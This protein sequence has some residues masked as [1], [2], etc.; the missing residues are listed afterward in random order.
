MKSISIIKSFFWSILL[1]PM[2][3]LGQT[4]TTQQPAAPAEE[5]PELISPSMEFTGVQ[6]GDNSI[7]L[8][9]ALKAKVNGQLI[10]LYKMKVSFFQVANETD[11]PLGFV[12]TDGKGN[13]VLN[14]KGDSLKTDAEG[15]LN[16][17]AVFAG[18]KAMDAAE[19]VTAFK[20][21]K[22]II[23]P[24]KE[25]SLLSVQLKL[26]DIGS[27]SES[28]VPEATVG[29]YVK[30]SFLPLKLGEGTTDENGEATIEVPQSLPGDAKGNITLIGKLDENEIY[31][32][33]E[34]SAVQSWG[35]PVSDK[36]QALPRAL[37]STHPP[38]WMLITFI[39]LVGTVWGHYLIIIIQLFRLRKEE[40][41][42][43]SP[44]IDPMF[45]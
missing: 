19:E 37:W 32:N 4:D 33:L 17:K 27:G 22:L 9:A 3:L 16:F 39:V 44:L 38:I 36:P 40:P 25:D 43:D 23:T 15:K 42:P 28:P 20:R 13:A 7:D 41:S 31:G 2:A 29:V 10:N 30:R 45:K 12:I 5:E 35:V 6:K 26:V 24:V 1:L 14:V 8:K 21:A 34:A 11:I 18:N